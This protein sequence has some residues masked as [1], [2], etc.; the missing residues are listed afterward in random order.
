M[1]CPEVAGYECWAK[2]F[3]IMFEP[4]LGL[5]RA[6]REHRFGLMS[7]GSEELHKCVNNNASME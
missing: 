2:A 5:R 6:K 3:W 1:G 4:I 7:A